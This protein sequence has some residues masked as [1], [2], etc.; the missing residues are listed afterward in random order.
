MTIH[1]PRHREG[2]I[3]TVAIQKIHKAGLPRMLCMLAMTVGG[4]NK[5]LIE[6]LAKII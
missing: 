2:A 3:A 4:D 5:F 6:S 1:K